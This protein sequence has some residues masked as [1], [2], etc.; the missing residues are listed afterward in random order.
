MNKTKIDWATM[1][2]NPVTGCRHGCPYCYARRT[3]RRFDASLED[4]AALPGGL[5]V[6]EDKI[7]ATPYPYGFEPT[8]HR[9]RLN[10]P[11]RQGEPQTVFV[12]S[13]A[14]LF[15]RWVPTGWI[16][17][18]LDACQQ[19]P[20][21]RYLFLT[22]NPARYLELDQVALLPHENNFWYGSTVANEEAMAMYPMPWAN[23]NT[24]WSMEPLLGPVDMSKAE[25]LPQWV[26]LGAETGNRTDK[27]I[28]C[29]EWVDKIV[30]FCAE[31]EI[32]VF[33]KDNLRAYF[34]D[35][36]ASAFPWDSQEEPGQN[37]KAHYMGR[38]ERQ[39]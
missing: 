7:K 4:R 37:W 39:E 33:Y 32:P 21:H 24:F 22:K 19:A 10:Q 25:G 3:A 30:K 9:Y 38:F 2:W 26:I 17:D 29:R 13:M 8:L 6:L 14:D 1:S 36:P 27:V 16:R 23:I 5:H 15:G 31:N 11:E 34:P 20:Q 28:P 18:V 12:C 35:L